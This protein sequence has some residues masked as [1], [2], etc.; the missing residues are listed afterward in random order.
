VAEI[1]VGAKALTMADHLDRHA[2]TSA[3]PNSR[4]SD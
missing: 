2:A 1:G 3:L 4:H